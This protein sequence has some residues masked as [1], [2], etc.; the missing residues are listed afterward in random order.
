[1][2]EPLSVNITYPVLG[3]IGPLTGPN[4]AEVGYVATEYGVP[5]MVPLN[6]DSRWV[7]AQME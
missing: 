5:L 7:H 4:A 2:P 3:I 6:S 1:M